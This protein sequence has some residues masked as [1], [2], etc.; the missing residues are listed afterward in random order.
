MATV[1][2]A[3]E[4]SPGMLDSHSHRC[5]REDL[6]VEPRHMD[7]HAAEDHNEDPGQRL[8]R[9]AVPRRGA[10]SR[11]ASNKS[12]HHMRSRKGRTE[13]YHSSER[14]LEDVHGDRCKK[15]VDKRRDSYETRRSERSR[16]RSRSSQGVSSDRRRHGR[17]RDRSPSRTGKMVLSRV[18]FL[19]VLV[20]FA[21]RF[22]GIVL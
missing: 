12:N 9:G 17:R 8:K 10:A 2:D 22:A 15:S 1:A 7:L 19:N 13:S 6:S 3:P 14:D 21:G 16:H 5:H 4:A 11:S 18:V 20:L